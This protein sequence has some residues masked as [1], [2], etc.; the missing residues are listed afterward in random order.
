MNS[1]IV[2]P[3]AKGTG[4]LQHCVF[5][6]DAAMANL[7]FGLIGTGERFC[8]AT[9]IE[10]KTHCGVSAHAKGIRKKNKA[11]VVVDAFYV[12]GG[13]ILARPT[14][15]IDPM[16]LK[17]DVPRKYL[18]Q[19]ET[20][21]LT[22]AEW[23]N[24][25]IDARTHVEDSGGEDDDDEEMEYDDKDEADS[26]PS[27]L[28]EGQYVEEEL[29]TG[30]I[31]EV[32]WEDSQTGE[33]GDWVPSMKS[34][35]AAIDLLGSILNSS[36]RRHLACIKALNARADLG[37][38]EGNET[39]KQVRRLLQMVHEHKN[40]ADSVH[41]VLEADQVSSTLTLEELRKEMD[42]FA[43]DLQDFSAEARVTSESIL[44]MIALIRQRAQA[45]D[46]N[47]R[48]CIA[49][50]EA[51]IGGFPRPPSPSL[52]TPHQAITTTDVG[53]TP[54]GT[55][56]I[57]GTDTTITANMLFNLV[58]ELQGKVDLLTERAKHTGIV[59]NGVAF[60]SESELS[61]WFARHNPS[62]AGRAAMVDFQSIWA[63]AESDTLEASVWLSDL[64]KS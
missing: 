45:R 62:G 16:I 13:I 27:V 28:N 32:D 49:Q 54:L 58:R 29:Q 19:L 63:Y 59:F 24:L 23:K 20:G 18:R 61:A 11:K 33:G 36:T 31:F 7:C 22:T 37:N 42:K 5:I 15:K 14:A 17:R 55:A 39:C 44:K 9:K 4:K 12:P 1:P 26:L 56:T 53:D 40:L 10:G 64:E 25:I 46:D 21:K 6:D 30:D 8:M 34:H 60:N 2:V 38:R 57:G 3:A 50:M 48:A 47:M 35:R 51:V 43:V 41:A 52:T